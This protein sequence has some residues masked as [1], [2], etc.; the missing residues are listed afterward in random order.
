MARILVAT[1]GFS[2]DFILKRIYDREMPNV[3][4][5]VILAL[6][7]DEGS[8]GRIKDAYN[9]LQMTLDKTGVKSSLHKIP[10]SNR[11][12]GDL[13]E[14][15]REIA[16]RNPEAS[17]EL[18]LT[19]GPRILVVAL[20]LAAISLS[21]DIVERI[22]VTVYGENFP[23]TLNVRLHQILVLGRLDGKS[24]QI[25][26][27]I[28]EGVTDNARLMKEVGMPKS[29]FYLKLA[30]LEELGLIRREGRGRVG[31]QEGVDNII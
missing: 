31:L 25:L 28:A 26:H 10:Y 12:I 29:S 3:D 11:I 6:W 30:E 16:L 4:E 21:E 18:F 14:K 22:T 24:E 1:L 9:L 15:L 8:W 5:A 27:A 17:I 2:M 7:T 23:G 20:L 13:R 19:G